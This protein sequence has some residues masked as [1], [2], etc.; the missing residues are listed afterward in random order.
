MSTPSPAVPA[1]TPA[2][3]ACWWLGGNLR[4]AARGL[5][6]ALLLG[7]YAVLADGAATTKGVSF[8]EGLQLAVG[9]NVWRTGDHRAEGANGDL[10]KRWATLPFLLWRPRL[11]GPEDQMGRIFLFEQGNSPEQLLRQGRRM[12]LLLGV[13]TGGLV[14]WAARQALGGAAGWIALTLYVSSPHLVAFGAIVSTDMS[15]TLALFGGTVAVWALLHRVTVASLGWSLCSAGLLALAKLSGLIILPVAAVLVM[16]RLAA[17][18]PLPVRIGP[19]SALVRGRRAQAGVFVGLGLAHLAVGWAAIWAHYGFRFV[20]DPR[21]GATAVAVGFP[22]PPETGGLV[23]LVEGLRRARWL[24]EGYCRGVEWLL[25]TTDR[26]PGFMAGQAKL[27]GWPEFFPYAI[28]V[29]TQP[30]LFLFLALGGAAVWWRR[31]LLPGGSRVFYPLIPQI[32]LVVIYLGI[33]VTEDINIG[34]RH[35]LPIYPSLF[36]LGSAASC[37]VPRWGWGAAGIGL[38]L[39]WRLLETV[40][41]RPDF[42]AYFGPQAGGPRAGYRHLVDSSL[43][44]GMDLPGLRRW[45]DVNNPRG[46]EPVFLAYFGTDSPR[47]RGIKCI[48]LPGFRPRRERAVYALAPGI[49]A[50]SA[51]LLQGAY[52]PAFGPW[53]PIYERIYQRRARNLRLFESTAGQPER[54]AELLRQKPASFWQQEFHTYD[55][56][57]FGRLCAWL[58]RSGRPPEQVG[59]SILIW[60][61]TFADLQ[62]ALEGP[63]P[64]L[65]V[66]PEEWQRVMGPRA[67]QSEEGIR[68]DGAGN[69]LG[70]KGR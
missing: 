46:K 43:D 67:G 19:L 15:V 38:L 49:Y 16:V 34:H 40:S 48:R 9:Y 54:R 2:R 18:R 44:W 37:L 61:L 27:G 55:Y 1:P 39:G 4:S 65:E 69:V 56:F 12:V 51:T 57:R 32:A 53:N 10:V 41:L 47:H 28:W 5:G 7:V 60:R 31:R 17:G 58:R 13:L 30:A 21:P 59:H 26:L 62:A 29:K 35:V 64:E 20:A 66:P 24:P 23:R 50:I 42:L 70:A 68:I 45:L 6:V 33:A 63:P 14:F 22:L 3:G 8:D 25:S 52:L 11:I 36:V